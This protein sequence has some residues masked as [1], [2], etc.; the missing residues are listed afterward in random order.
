MAGAQSQEPRAGRLQVRARSRKLTAA[1]VE[2][3][4]VDERSV[5][6]H[7]LMR[8]TAHL[9]PTDDLGWLEPLFAD[10]I[11]AQSIR[12]LDALGVGASERDKALR[13]IR[14]ALDVEGLLTRSD[15]MGVAE[16]SGLKID[17]ER[18]THLSVLTVVG[19]PA[20]IG[21]DAGGGRTFAA[22]SDW[23]G[24]LKPRPRE[25][26]LAELARRYFAAF[27]PATERDFAYWSGLPL[28]DC[29]E[30]MKRI[31]GELEPIGPGDSALIAMRGSVARA[32]RS[33][34]VRLL[35][36]FDT[37]LMGYASR[38]YAVD[39]AGAKEIL[40]GGGILRPTICVD[41]RLVGTW[42]SKRVGRKLSVALEWFS[43][44]DGDWAEA[45]AAEVEDIA[46]FEGPEPTAA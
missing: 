35:G 25:E 15:A 20:F 7:W 6:R 23:L 10:R 26:A 42:R 41:G 9:V 13:A 46:R 27:S 16:R 11:R 30:G 28:G 2:G 33:P 40:P 45:L 29:R 32:P 39:Q 18:R 37:Y 3:A 1:D 24:P 8:M 43:E 19:G 17:V 44:P 22:R 21:P 36:A 31:A 4:R 34:V 5:V 12:R 38:G 14:R